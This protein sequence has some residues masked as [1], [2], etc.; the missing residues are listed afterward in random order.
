MKAQ[1]SS[2][3]PTDPST[4]QSAPSTHQ[5]ASNDYFLQPTSAPFIDAVVFC[6]HL[7]YLIDAR[8]HRDAQ[9]LRGLALP[10]RPHLCMLAVVFPTREAVPHPLPL[11]LSLLIKNGNIQERPSTKRHPNLS[12]MIPVVPDLISGRVCT[13]ARESCSKTFTNA[14]LLLCLMCSYL[15]LCALYDKLYDNPK[16]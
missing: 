7:F 12:D 6:Y 3:H 1:G 9:S 4:H 14:L 8:C 15:F 11:S 13:P 5:S 2:L 10:R 16:P